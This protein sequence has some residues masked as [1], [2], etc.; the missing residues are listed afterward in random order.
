M[1]ADLRRE[2][3]ALVATGTAAPS[4]VQPAATVGRAFK[5]VDVDQEA[6][7]AASGGA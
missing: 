6:R 1:I 3:S 7:E 4:G 5:T 2:R